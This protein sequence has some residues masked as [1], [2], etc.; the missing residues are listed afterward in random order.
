MFARQ[1]GSKL[2]RRGQL[3]HKRLALQRARYEVNRA[4][5]QYDAVDPANRLVAG[6]LERRWN[7]ALAVQ[8]RLEE[9]VAE[10]TRQRPDAVS[11][12]T[13]QAVMA[14]AEDVPRLWD[15]PDTTP[16]V[17]KRIVRTVIKEI[18]VNSEVTRCASSC[19]GKA[20]I[21]PSCG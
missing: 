6:S 17:R 9:E 2:D 8:S 1:G 7:D 13:K 21:T 3:A 5:R 16:D 10:L 20:A 4:Q 19:I 18:V 11:D 14:L 15:H 12:E